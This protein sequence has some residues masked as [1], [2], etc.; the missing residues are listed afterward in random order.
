MSGLQVA[1]LTAEIAMLR[2]HVARNT[3]Q[4]RARRRQAAREKRRP[5]HDASSA[6]RGIGS[7]DALEEPVALLAQMHE[8][9][10]G[11]EAMVLAAADMYTAVRELEA[12]PSYWTI[13]KDGSQ[14]SG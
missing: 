11:A 14:D 6:W 5:W 2:Q 9:G 7:R 13:L 10:N 1:A 3:E 4:G 8:A 12:H